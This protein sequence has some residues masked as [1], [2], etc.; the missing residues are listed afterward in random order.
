MENFDLALATQLVSSQEDFPVD[1]DE[2]WLW[3]GYSRKDN[4]KAT[5]VKNFEEGL[6]FE[7]L[8]AQEL[9]P[10]GGYSNREVIKLTTDAAKEFALLAQ[11]DN[12]KVDTSINKGV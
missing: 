1:F 3:V 10:Q 2:L 12:G 8:I 5:L 11:T 6:D 7:I 4:A 9:R